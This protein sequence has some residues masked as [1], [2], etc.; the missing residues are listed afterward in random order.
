MVKIERLDFT[1]P[2][3]LRTVW[4]S[5]IARE[6]WEPKI[7]SI[8]ASWH[9]IERL[10]LLHN[11]RPGV[12]QSITP[13]ELPIVQNWALT[14]NIPMAIVGLDGVSE[15]YGNAS[16][17]YVPGQRFTFRVYFGME[18][19]RFLDAWQSQDDISIGRMLGF[20]PC[21][22]AS[23]QLHWKEEGWRDLT[24]HSFGQRD[25][26]NE[27]YNNVLLRHIGIRGVFHL[28]CSVSCQESVKIGAQIIGIM[29]HTEGLTDSADW[30]QQLLVMPME[31]TSLHG[32]AMV[33]TPILK[34]IY[35]SDPIPVKATMRLDSELYPLHGASGNKF[36]FQ[37]VVTS[38]LH[39]N[40]FKSKSS[41]NE[42]HQF[43]VS[44]LKNNKIKGKVLDL[45]CGDG[46]LLKAIQA[47]HPNTKL[48][49]VDF[50]ESVITTVVPG[51][52]PYKSDIYDFHYWEEVDLVL[53]SSQRLLEVPE[54]KASA[55]MEV[56]SNFSK[57]L[58]LYNYGEWEDVG[59]FIDPYF[60][61]VTAVKNDNYKALL[62][63]SKHGI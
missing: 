42:A 43:I 16:L 7:R 39:L 15:S 50:D 8:S 1:I 46:T 4:V 60:T 52:I 12:L 23:F 14:K 19:E 34:T 41:M 13:E 20:P 3:F 22:I 59:R 29:M 63:E 37:N 55:L 32:V 54:Y 36:P 35:A 9:A 44:I 26:R 38:R 49:G 18:P 33:V 17:P 31:W 6:Y 28:P 53:L 56:I 24:I 58:L 21:C 61:V 27:A 47:A 11:M 57:R 10:T 2:D 40:G 45:G 62:L 48:L 5:E 25:Q 51:V 30:L